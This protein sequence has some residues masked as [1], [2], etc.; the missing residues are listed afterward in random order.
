MDTAPQSVWMNPSGE[1]FTGDSFD[2]LPIAIISRE[3]E[4]KLKL[5]PDGVSMEWKGTGGAESGAAAK[6]DMSTRQRGDPQN[7]VDLTSMGWSKVSS[8]PI[9]GLGMWLRK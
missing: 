8:A 5:A 2:F 7:D 1:K 9:G 4:Q 3:E 6:L